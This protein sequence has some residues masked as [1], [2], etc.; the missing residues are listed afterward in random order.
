M[1][2]RV[3]VLAAI[4]LSTAAYA[5]SYDVQIGAFRDPDTSKIQLPADVGELRTTAGPNGMTRFMVGPFANRD[6]AKSALAELKSAGFEGAF[7]RKSPAQGKA[8][9]VT[10]SA[11]ADHRQP[12]MTKEAGRQDQSSDISQQDLDKLM[13]L[14]AEER[15][16]IVFLDGRLHR[17]V[18]DEFV[19]LTD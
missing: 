7:I 5:D 18:G 9:P 12:K 6:D 16:D 11:D 3:I 1:L 13:T 19:P 17:K 15:Q 8:A 4:F 14:S 2:N 10:A